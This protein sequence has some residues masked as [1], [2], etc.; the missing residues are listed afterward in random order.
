MLDSSNY[1]IVLLRIE[2]L[3]NSFSLFDSVR[4]SLKKNH[5]FG[6]ASTI[7]HHILA[8]SKWFFTLLRQVLYD[9]FA[10]GTPACENHYNLLKYVENL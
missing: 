7:I 5:E 1:N 10:L 3:K 6:S 9:V 4:Y 8:R 2:F